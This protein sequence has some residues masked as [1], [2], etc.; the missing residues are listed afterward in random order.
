MQPFSVLEEI[1]RVVCVEFIPPFFGRGIETGQ[2]VWRDGG[3]ALKV[4]LG[5]GVSVI[6]RGGED[7]IPGIEREDIV[8]MIEVAGAELEGVRDLLVAAGGVGEVR[9]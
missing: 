5:F 8:I 3:G 2:I 4:I 7:M 9:G 6:N 1:G